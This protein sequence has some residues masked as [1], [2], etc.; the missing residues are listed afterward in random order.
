M[1]LHGLHRSGDTQVTKYLR[2]IGFQGRQA[3]EWVIEKIQADVKD[4]ASSAVKSTDDLLNQTRRQ[5]D[6][7]TIATKRG[8]D[9]IQSAAKKS[10]DEFQNLTA[11]PPSQSIPKL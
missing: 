5:I 4:I 2:T 11:P 1:Q 10:L 7:I 3:M 9:D 8:M 6:D